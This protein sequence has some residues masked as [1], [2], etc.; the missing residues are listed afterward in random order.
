MV[1]IK[2]AITRY[3]NAE[4]AHSWIGAGLPSDY[5]AIEAELKNSHDELHALIEK[6]LDE[7]AK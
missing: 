5:S 3:A 1:G 6:R 2:Q 7:A 4:V